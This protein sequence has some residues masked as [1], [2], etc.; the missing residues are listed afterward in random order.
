M[1]ALMELN[2]GEPA[3]GID[4]CDW[5]GAQFMEMWSRTDQSIPASV[6]HLGPGF[7]GEEA[8]TDFFAQAE[9][10]TD[11]NARRTFGPH[12]IVEMVRNLTTF[13]YAAQLVIPGL[14]GMTPPE[15]AGLRQYYK[16]LYRKK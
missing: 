14:R 15:Q 16:K 5:L 3:T 10:I 2:I 12:G 4:S 7:G 9:N 13:S 11:P 8:E 6:I 1:D